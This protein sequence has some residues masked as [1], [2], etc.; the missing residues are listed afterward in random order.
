MESVIAERDVEVEENDQLIPGKI[1]VFAPQ[2]HSQDR[3]KADYWGCQIAVSFGSYSRSREIF[4]MDSY[5][6]LM[7]AL[8]MI[9]SEIEFSPAFRN[10]KLRLWGNPLT[11]TTEVFDWKPEGEA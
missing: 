1:Q 4:G 10:G 8:K 5:Q 11:S 9:P 7:L 6:A 2:L 3:P